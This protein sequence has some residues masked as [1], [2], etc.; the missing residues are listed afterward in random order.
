MLNKVVDNISGS[1][2]KFTTAFIHWDLWTPL[3]H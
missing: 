1:T 3:A 2:C